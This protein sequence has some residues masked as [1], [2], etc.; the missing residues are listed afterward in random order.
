MNGVIA[1]ANATGQDTR[2]IEA[3]SHAYAAKDG[4]YKS[5][6]QWRKDENGDLVGK[7]EIPMSVG[8][9]GG[10]INVHPTAKVCS[11]ILGVQSAGELACVIAA[12][13]LAQNFSAMRALAS[14]GIQKGHMRLHARNLAA[15]AGARSD[16]IDKIVEQMTK[17]GNISINRARELLQK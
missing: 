4:R 17:E 16:Q 2:A 13:G 6:T 8:I 3:A 15:A 5:L 1:V 7:I 14:E 9:I 11:K 12:A 10:I